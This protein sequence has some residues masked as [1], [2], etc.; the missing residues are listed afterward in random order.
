MD[1]P[2]PEPRK[3]SRQ[4]SWFWFEGGDLFKALVFSGAVFSVLTLPVGIV[5][6]LIVGFSDSWTLA[7]WV[8]GGIGLAPLLLTMAIGTILEVVAV[9]CRG[10]QTRGWL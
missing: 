5:V 3:R 4:T 2:D 7:L 1:T 9:F 10:W 6:G 8:G